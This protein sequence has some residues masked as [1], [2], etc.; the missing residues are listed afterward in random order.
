MTDYT[1][2]VVGSVVNANAQRSD[3]SFGRWEIKKITF[4]AAG[5]GNQG[6]HNLITI[7]AKSFVAGGYFIITTS[8]VSDGTNGTISFL[9]QTA[10][11]G[12]LTANGSEC[13]LGDIIQFKHMDLEDAVG[14]ANYNASA[15]TFDLTV[16]T[17][18]VTAGEGYL[19]L[20]IV[21]LYDE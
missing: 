7:P 14:M 4:T 13:V 9:G 1:G 11:H 10:M 18:D 3:D 15:D 6:T 16:A 19:L 17:N 2:N 12:T 8:L 20:N 21:G 5:V